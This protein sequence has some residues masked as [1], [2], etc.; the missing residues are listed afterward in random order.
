MFSNKY[1]FTY[2]AVMVT[3]VAVILSS[4]ATLLQ[5][6]QEKNEK[7][8]KMSGIL[9][10]AELKPAEKSEMLKTYNE[11]IVE[12][13]VINTDGEIVSKY[14]DGEFVKGD[15]RA[16]DIKLEDELHKLDQMEKGKDVE[17]HFPIYIAKNDGERI[18]IIPVRGK[19]LWGPIWGNVAL[20]N[21]FRTIVG[22]TFGHKSETPG[23]GAEIANKPFQNQFIG[24]TIFNEDYEFTSIE[25]VK[26]GVENSNVDPK[27]GV[28]AISGGT[29]TSNGVSSMLKEVLS[30]Y[31]PFV[32][33][34]II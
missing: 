8:E 15:F 2:A 30:V 12:E 5:P 6:L 13:W 16:F 3:V 28:D 10:S 19:G 18:F 32:K 29:I 31:K 9:A 27:H 25:V 7:I 17:P 24:K 21:D 26:G 34:H 23:L 14:K 20:K 22:T 33:K 11:K 4:A 1:I